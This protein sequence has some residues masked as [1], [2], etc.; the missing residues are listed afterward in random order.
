MESKPMS[1]TERQKRYR[2]KNKV[3]YRVNMILSNETDQ[4]VTLLASHCVVSK[5]EVFEDAISRRFYSVLNG[6]SSEEEKV[7]YGEDDGQPV[8]A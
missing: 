4:R 3:N 6:L 7:F 5:K 1:N 2:W 8:T